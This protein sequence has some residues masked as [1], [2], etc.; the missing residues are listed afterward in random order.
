MCTHK[1]RKWVIHRYLTEFSTFQPSKLLLKGR[2][3]NH[4]P[5]LW[6]HW[7][8]ARLIVL[9]KGLRI[10]I[11]LS[12]YN[13]I[14]IYYTLATINIYAQIMAHLH[15][16]ATTSTNV[17]ITPLIYICVYMSSIQKASNQFYFGSGQLKMKNV[18]VS[19]YSKS[20]RLIV[21]RRDPSDKSG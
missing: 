17:C 9:I 11:F 10:C 18:L 20:D 15:G 13:M 16:G 19:Y 4:F 8:Q 2:V 12:L 5:K 14:N 21:V 6:L 3:I 1:K 7:N